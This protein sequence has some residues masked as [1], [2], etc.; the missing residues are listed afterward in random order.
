MTK[1]DILIASRRIF[2]RKGYDGLGMRILAS[3]LD[4]ALS[5]LYHHF[6]NKDQLLKSMFDWTNTSLGE[7]RLNLPKTDSAFKMLEQRIEF[8]FEHIEQVVA[9]LKY[10]FHFRDTFIEK[11]DGILPAKAYR[12]MLE[13]VECG[14]ATGEFHV[15]KP[16]QAA[17]MLTHCVNGFLLEYYPKRLVDTERKVLVDE[18][19]SFLVRAL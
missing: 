18:I 19:A 3:E 10:Y 5:V 4:C 17:R 2:A 14:N 1:E 11:D 15:A 13:V 16:E 8:Q 9:V 12:H 7:A 6:E